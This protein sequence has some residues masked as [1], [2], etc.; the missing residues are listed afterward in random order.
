[1]EQM[2]ELD[3]RESITKV[4]IHLHDCANQPKKQLLITDPN[5]SLR[6]KW[7]MMVRDFAIR[8]LSNVMVDSICFVGIVVDI[9][10][11]DR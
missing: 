10:L 5:S 6:S 9:L 7:C 3:L 4:Y 8:F 1:M 2:H 11:C